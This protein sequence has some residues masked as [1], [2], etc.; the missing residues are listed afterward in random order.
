MIHRGAAVVLGL[1]SGLIVFGAAFAVLHSTTAA[2]VIA[3]VAATV[4][5][6]A[7]ET[8]RLFTFD[9]GACPKSLKVSSAAVSVLGLILLTRLTFFMADPSRVNCS[10]IPA[11]RWEVAH[12]CLTAYHIAAELVGTA[13]VYEGSLYSV[14]D[15]GTGPRTPRKLGP[16]NV[17]VFEYPPQFLLLPR[18][19]QLLTPD[20]M[21][22]RL[23]WFAFSCGVL[24]AGL[25]VVPAQI[26]GA[27][28]TRALLLS[29]LLWIAIPGTLST[30]QKGNV[31][32]VIIAASM[33]AMVLFARGRKATGAALLA[34]AIVSKLWPGMLI[35]YLM[36]RREWRAVLWT[37]GFSLLWSGITLAMFGWGA[38]AAFL[39][40][41]PGL[42]SGEAFPAF[43]NPGAMAI[44]LS[45]PNILF[46]LK[47]FGFPGATFGVAKVLGWVYTA[48][49]VAATIWA[50]R[51]PWR[52]HEQPFVW[53]SILTI[54]TLRSPFL[55][56]TYG[57]I[58]GL[59]LLT[60]VAAIRIPTARSLALTG[61]GFIALNANWPTD[62]PI[63]PRFLA[64]TSLVPLLLMIGLTIRGLRPVAPA[65]ATP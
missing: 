34:F 50:A 43:R 61:L 20:F 31:Q 14:P 60:L 35:V 63:D 28:G 17:D 19:F 39:D 49:A 40:H 64:L 46:K 57:V 1:A 16:F 3:L 26:G 36:A 48:V 41:A 23:L 9:E 30:L 32:I 6:W 29:P 58:P 4:V 11:S 51:R 38:Y 59:W 42:L 54:A 56:F 45:I 2:V 5:A 53:L 65:P 21:D 8:R 24:L 22:L 15:S 44:N 62:W 27:I 47:L 33:I 37:T 55:P 25:I 13:N 7:T 18:A 52:P 10:V 12:S